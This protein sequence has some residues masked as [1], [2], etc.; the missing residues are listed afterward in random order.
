[1]FHM[2]FI[3]LPGS[4]KSS[5]KKGMIRR[6]RQHSQVCLTLEEALLSS[7]K[8]SRDDIFTHYLLRILPNGVSERLLNSLFIRSRYRFIAQNHF[9]SNASASLHVILASEPFQLMSCEER[10]LALSRF[11]RTAITYQAVREQIN[12][13]IPVAF[14]EGF[15]QRGTS[16]FLL[17]SWDRNSVRAESVF[18]YF[19]AVPSPDLLVLVE[20]DSG[21]CLNR[22]ESRGLPGRLKHAKCS[23]VSTFFESCLAYFGHIS[24]W[25]EKMERP[26]LRIDNNGLPQDAVR[27]LSE[28]VMDKLKGE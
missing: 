10:G 17:P 26:I 6:L 3:G 20:A 23:S 7:L 28:R 14:D 4:G 5:V 27:A 11:L 2:E 19:D 22:I 25:A 13:A 1:M 9:L 16:L 12:E 24:K 15:F 21:K 18:P 8:R